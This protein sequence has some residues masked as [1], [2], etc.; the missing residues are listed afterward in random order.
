MRID[1]FHPS[2]AYRQDE[3]QK[4]GMFLKTEEPWKETQEGDSGQSIS[5][6]LQDKQSRTREIANPVKFVANSTHEFDSCHI[7]STGHARPFLSRSVLNSLRSM[8]ILP[9]G[10]LLTLLLAYRPGNGFFCV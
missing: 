7:S 2:K 4:E 8:T 10:K 9:V 6:E 1:F 3:Q 5:L